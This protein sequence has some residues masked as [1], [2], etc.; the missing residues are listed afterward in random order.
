MNKVH[1]VAQG[2][3]KQ[4]I[5]LLSLTDIKSS[6]QSGYSTASLLEFQL[7][8]ILPTASKVINHCFKKQSYRA[9]HCGF[10]LWARGFLSW[11]LIIHHAFKSISKEQY[12]AF[13]KKKEG[14]EVFL[15]TCGMGIH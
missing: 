14:A 3:N 6:S 15:I 9:V 10:L 13:G 5:L 12:F 11:C 1:S 7:K 4:F 2:N 8:N